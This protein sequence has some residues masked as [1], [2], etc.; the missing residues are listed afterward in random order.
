M[1][2][3]NWWFKIT[4]ASKCCQSTSWG[5]FET[6]SFCNCDIDQCN[7]RKAAE[8]ANNDLKFWEMIDSAEQW[9][10]LSYTR[11]VPCMSTCQYWMS[12][13]L[14]GKFNIDLMQ[15]LWSNLIRP[16]T[17]TLEAMAGGAKRMS[18]AFG[19]SRKACMALIYLGAPLLL[20][21]NST[22]RT[23]NFHQNQLIKF[24]FIDQICIDNS[25]LQV[26]TLTPSSC[27]RLHCADY[28]S[29]QVEGTSQ[30]CRVGCPVLIQ[31]QHTHLCTMEKQTIDLIWYD[32]DR[33]ISFNMP[34]TSITFGV[35]SVGE[36]GVNHVQINKLTN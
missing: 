27:P 11:W 25:S 3:W 30:S 35:S 18:P 7:N 28:I 14:L 20:F 22:D 17:V 16:F 4:R 5:V 31:F 6:G 9:L 23:Q 15:L 24:K 19:L 10:S 29:E 2:L 32:C 8:L 36:V 33:L 34:T 21:L 13:E 26:P 12:K 1:R